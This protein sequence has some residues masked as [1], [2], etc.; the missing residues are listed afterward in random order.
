M[1]SRDG[2]RVRCYWRR[3]SSGEDALELWLQDATFVDLF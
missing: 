3:T 1:A 2:E